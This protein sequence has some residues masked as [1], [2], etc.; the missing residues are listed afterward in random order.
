MAVILNHMSVVD[1]RAKALAIVFFIFLMNGQGFTS[2][3]I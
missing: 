2:L 1:W 3:T